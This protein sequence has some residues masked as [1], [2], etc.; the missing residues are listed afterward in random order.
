MSLTIL[1]SVASSSSAAWPLQ[2]QWIPSIMADWAY[3]S[4]P[5][6]PG[7][8]YEDAVPD[9]THASRSSS[10]WFFDGTNVY[11]RFM[12][13]GNPIN[14]APNPDVLYSYYWQAM[15][16]STGNSFPEYMV[17]VDGNN[18][19]DRIITRYNTGNDTTMDGATGNS[20]VQS[21]GHTTEASEGI[22]YTYLVNGRVRVGAIPGSNY[23]GNADYYIDFYVP[24]S[25]LS[26]SDGSTPPQ[27]I[28]STT[29]IKIA[30]GTSDAR[31]TIGTDLVGQGGGYSIQTLFADMPQ[32]DLENAVYGGFG[33]LRDTRFPGAAIGQGIWQTGETV[34]V[35]GFGWPRRVS[36]YNLNVRITDPDGSIKWEGPIQFDANGSVTNASTLLI[37]PDA[38]PGV[39]TILVSSPRTSVFEPK[40]TFLVSTPRMVIDKSVDKT[41]ASPGETLIYTIN[42]QN[43]G[44][45][46]AYSIDILDVLP[47]EVEYL[48]NSTAPSGA[49]FWYQH[50]SGGAFDNSS[51]APVVAIKLLFT[52]GS[53]LA[54]GASGQFTITVRVK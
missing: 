33:I 7:F 18:N 26:R 37:G 16:E 2:A 13:N 10:F 28:T 8:S 51:I 42:Y 24:L 11:F 32:F 38:M 21:S 48:S 43:S 52:S 25:W 40:D 31:D 49:Q 46:N 12:L 5:V 47:P 14:T 29:R 54:P 15:I 17:S 23:N 34:T 39:Y 22:T 50:A 35:N 44:N 53:F 41:A 4:E 1:F 6:S 45:A 20:L 27:A 9:Q 36:A 3:I 19:P 30:Y